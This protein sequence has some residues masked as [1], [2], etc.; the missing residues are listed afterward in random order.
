MVDFPELYNSIIILSFII[1][2][3]SLDFLNFIP[4]AINLLLT[5]LCD[6]LIFFSF[7]IKSE[8]SLQDIF[9]LQY[10]SIRNLLNSA[11]YLFI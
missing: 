6:N 1:I 9:L 5:E 8:I 7:N 3:S 4:F 2:L 11:D 10:K